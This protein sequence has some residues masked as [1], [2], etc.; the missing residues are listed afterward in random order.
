MMQ[1][2]VLLISLVCL[3]L[4]A[5]LHAASIVQNGGFEIGE[6][7]PW[8]QDHDLSPGMG[9]DW[10]VTSTESHS[11]QFSAT[12]VGNKEIRQNFGATATATITEFSF[13]IK[14]PAGAPFLFANFFYSDGTNTGL[15]LL[16]TTTEWQFFNITNRLAPGKDLTGFSVY[17][18]DGTGTPRSHLDDVTATVVPEPGA[19]ALSAA[20][21]LVLAAARRVRSQKTV[22]R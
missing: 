13:W 19:L 18:F 9:E 5:T 4:P 17:G 22:T 14:H 11:G 12:N 7:D 10:N 2:R 3:L 6:L 20:G 1:V 21:A 16:V 15:S 8:Y